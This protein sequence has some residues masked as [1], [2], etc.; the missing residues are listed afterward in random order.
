MG[1]HV[2]WQCRR[3][4]ND[5]FA[6]SAVYADIETQCPCITIVW[7]Q[8]GVSI[9][10]V[11][12]VENSLPR[13]TAIPFYPS[14]KGFHSRQAGGQTHELTVAIQSEHAAALRIVHERGSPMQRAA[15]IAVGISGAGRQWIIG[16]PIGGWI[17]GM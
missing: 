4:I 11:A 1:P 10:V 15:K 17:G 13:W 9:G 5:L 12:K 14:R 7:S 16:G 2:G 8:D 3:R 6:G